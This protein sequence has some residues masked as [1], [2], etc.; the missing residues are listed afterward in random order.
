MN[1]GAPRCPKCGGLSTN[2][3]DQQCRFC[4][5]ALHQGYGA[6]QQQQQ[7][8]QQYAPQPYGAPP[9]NYGAPAQGYGAPQQFGA[10]QQQHGYGAPQPFGA[11]PPGYGPQPGYGAPQPFGGQYP[12]APVQSFGGQYGRQI[13]RGVFGSGWSSFFWLRLAIVGIAISLSLVGA[14]ISAITN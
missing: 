6:P 5:A 1:G 3:N 13:N 4:G 10:P 7:Q 14:C 2:P 12:M 11:P 9:P 8:Q